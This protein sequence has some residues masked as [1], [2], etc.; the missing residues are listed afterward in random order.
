MA[1]DITPQQLAQAAKLYEEMEK[2]PKAG[3]IDQTQTVN[4][5]IKTFRI[6]NLSAEESTISDTQFPKIQN[7]NQGL[8]IVS[9]ADEELLILVEFRQ[10]VDLDSFTLF[11]IQTAKEE[12]YSA[13][14]NI[15]LFK[16]DSLNRDFDDVKNNNKFDAKFA[17]KKEKLKNGQ[18][19]SLKKN[20]KSTVKFSKTK[21]LLIYISSNQD[22]TEQTYLNGIHF[23][24]SVKETT[25]MSK[26]EQ[27]AAEAKKKMEQ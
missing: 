4:D 25:D 17:A 5:Q 20:A 23:T 26:W 18:T 7:M 8:F 1:Q 21:Y 27:V 22:G 24:G 2:A 15:R 10:E 6:L 11:A 16:A 13:P 12:E 3:K 14:K 19:F 9:D